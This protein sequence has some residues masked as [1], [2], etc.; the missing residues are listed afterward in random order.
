MHRRISQTS[1]DPKIFSHGL[2]YETREGQYL[3]NHF[4]SCRQPVC[5]KGC[6]HLNQDKDPAQKSVDPS[7]DASSRPHTD[8]LRFLGK[9]LDLY[10]PQ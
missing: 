7:S 10:V 2:C 9:S 5:R 8:Q 6:A 4:I 1:F 3:G